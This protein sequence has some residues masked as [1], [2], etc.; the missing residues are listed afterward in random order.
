MLTPFEAVSV[1]KISRP[2]L[3]LTTLV[4]TFKFVFFF[5]PSLSSTLFFL[6]FLESEDESN[7]TSQHPSNARGGKVRGKSPERVMWPDLLKIRAEALL[8]ARGGDE[9]AAAG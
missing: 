2:L 4:F 3:C 5:P 8:S 1:L 7:E 9:G 6:F